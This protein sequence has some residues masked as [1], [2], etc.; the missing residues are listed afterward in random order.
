MNDYA[1]SKSGA[2]W[3]DKKSYGFFG[4]SKLI[5]LGIFR[6]NFYLKASIVF[7]GISFAAVTALAIVS[8]SMTIVLYAIPVFFLAAAYS[9]KPLQL[10][11]RRMG[12]LVVFLLFGPV[13]VMGGYFIQTGAF[14]SWEAFM[15]SLPF[16][17]FAAAILFANEIPDYVDDMKVGKRN[18]VGAIGSDKAFIAYYAL[19]FLA[20]FFVAL[21]IILEYVNVVGFLSFIPAVFA[22]RAA[23]V[24]RDF[25]REKAR[26]VESSRLTVVLHG[27]ASIFLIIGISL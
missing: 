24:M 16:G 3:Q 15:A 21:N 7:L 20:F 8:R 11:Y 9:Y 18:W 22:F 5:Q 6:E 17:I 13:P 14:P 1:D 10:S 12:E 23:R 4:G 2:D 25:P 27:M 19:V 26:L